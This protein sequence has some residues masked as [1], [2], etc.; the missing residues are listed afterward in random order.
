MADETVVL[1]GNP[2]R[3]EDSENG[4]SQGAQLTLSL[5]DKRIEGESKTRENNTGRMRTVYKVKKQ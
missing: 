4:S 3:V 5:R 2:A 1:R